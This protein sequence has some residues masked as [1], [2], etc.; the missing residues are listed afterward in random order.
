MVFAFSP[1]SQTVYASFSKQAKGDKHREAGILEFSFPG[2]GMRRIPLI[3]RMESGDEAEIWYFQP[4]V[5]HDGKTLAVASTYLVAGDALAA[6]N[7]CALFLVDLSDPERKV[8]RVP[9]PWPPN[10][11]D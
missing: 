6:K 3:D 11:L 2:G 4:S 10:A 1:N 8:T 5:S 9:V 7:D